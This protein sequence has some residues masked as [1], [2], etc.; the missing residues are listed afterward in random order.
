M[1]FVA[2]LFLIYPTA[3]REIKAVIPVEA[4]GSF[5]SGS[6]YFCVTVIF[7][8]QTVFRY[9]LKYETMIS[10]SAS[11]DH[12]FEMDFGKNFTNTMLWCIT[13]P[14][15]QFAKQRESWQ[16]VTQ[17][18]EGEDE[19]SLPTKLTLP[20]SNYVDLYQTK[21]T[22]NS[23]LLIDSDVPLAGTLELDVKWK[24]HKKLMNVPLLKGNT[25]CKMNSVA[26]VRKCPKGCVDVCPGPGESNEFVCLRE[27]RP[28]LRRS[29]PLEF[30]K[31]TDKLVLNAKSGIVRYSASLEAIPAQP[32]DSFS[33]CSPIGTSKNCHHLSRDGICMTEKSPCSTVSVPENLP[34]HSIYALH[35]PETSFVPALIQPLVDPLLF[36]LVWPKRRYPK[37]ISVCTRALLGISNESDAYVNQEKYINGSLLEEGYEGESSPFV[38]LTANKSHRRPTPFPGAFVLAEISILTAIVVCWLFDM[39]RRNGRH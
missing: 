10:P 3:A 20:T 22:G 13:S 4:E 27:Y 24:L 8:L 12:I 17:C 9:L 5:V 11:S 29:G 19:S 34:P 38:I 1:F 30:V 2:L 39:K 15:S 14:L 6:R 36:C 28:D 26:S 25:S 37:F 35:V 33:I 31:R 16:R 18:Y 23:L 21:N 7:E 32:S